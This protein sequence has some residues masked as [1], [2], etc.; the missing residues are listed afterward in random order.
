MGKP[1]KVHM[2]ALKHLFQYMAGLTDFIITFKQGGFDLRPS[3]DNLGN[4][5]DNGKSTTSFIVTLSKASVSFK[6]KLQGLPSQSTMEAELVAEALTMKKT[7]FFPTMMKGLQHL[8]SPRRWPPDLQ[9]AGR[10]R[11]SAVFS[12]QELVKE[13]RIDI[14]YVKIED[15]LVDITTKHRSKDT[16]RYLINL[17]YA[18]KV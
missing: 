7:V 12:I 9:L 17:L 18:F 5:P 8:C 4:N 6:V 13:G 2:A 3:F 14:V 16:N 1:F 15:H 11:D 10:A